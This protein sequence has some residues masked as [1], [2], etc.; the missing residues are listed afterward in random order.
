MTDCKDKMC[1]GSG[2]AQNYEERISQ[3]VAGALMN[4]DRV[5]VAPP[6][7]PRAVLTRGIEANCA[8]AGAC[9]S[10]ASSTARPMGLGRRDFVQ[11]AGVAP[12]F[13]NNTDGSP[14]VAKT[15][16]GAFAD[17]SWGG[18]RAMQPRGPFMARK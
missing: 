16:R 9:V 1:A 3:E 10:A 14:G 13:L 4:R 7:D 6:R 5:H 11:D 2:P 12:R 17:P 18:N 8:D 15:H